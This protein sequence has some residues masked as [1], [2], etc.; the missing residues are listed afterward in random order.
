MGK[1]HQCDWCEAIQEYLNVCTNR[2]P[3]ERGSKRAV[4]Q[5]M[6]EGGG[7]PAGIAEVISHWYA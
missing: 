1:K 2:D 4:M 7:L 6:S 5:M 3:K